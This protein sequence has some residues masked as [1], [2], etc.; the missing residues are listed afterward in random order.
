M[1][2]ASFVTVLCGAGVIAGLVF[3]LLTVI[4]PHHSAKPLSLALKSLARANALLVHEGPLEYS[5][6]LPFYT[7]SRIAV[8]NGRKGDLDFGS[9]YE[10]SR[11]LF[12]D[13]ARFTALW[14]GEGRLF[15][16]TRFP[17]QEGVAAR[18]PAD[19][20]LLLGR[21]GGRWLY[22]NKSIVNGQQ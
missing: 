17:W 14:K 2:R 12:L 20:T 13:D 22:T 18:L 16:V 6:G 15:L 4:E 11:H 7:G 9:R 21:Y 3:R 1:P 19:K 10:E 5:G 8:L